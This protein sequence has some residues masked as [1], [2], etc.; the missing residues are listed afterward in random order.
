MASLRGVTAFGEL[1]L[2]KLI[3]VLRENMDLVMDADA[4]AGLTVGRNP[5]RFP[6]PSAIASAY[7]GPRSFSCN[8]RRFFRVRAL[9]A[10]GSRWGDRPSHFIVLVRRNP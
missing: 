2:P 6:W 7:A 5:C 9:A 8:R 1:F 10:A 4:L 3:T